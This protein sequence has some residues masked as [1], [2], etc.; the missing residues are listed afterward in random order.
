VRALAITMLLVSA[1]VS[2]QTSS[3]DIAELKSKAAAGDAQ[4]QVEL[5][6][7]YEAGKEV[8]QN[9][10]QAVQ[11]Y[12]AAADQGDAEG[13]N[14]L[15]LMYRYGHGVNKDIGEALKWFRKAAKQGYASAMFNLATV[16]YN[17]QEMP[18]NDRLAYVWFALAERAG[19]KPATDGVQRLTAEMPAW[20]L[21]E[22][23]FQ[24]AQMLLLGE[25]VPA[26]RP[27]ALEIYKDLGA[28][29][30]V[31]S[32]VTLGRLYIYGK[33][34]PQ[35][36]T[37]AAEYCSHAA[38]AKY[39]PGM[40]CL[41]FLNAAGALGPG[42]D[43]EAFSWYEKAAKKGSAVGAYGLASMYARGRGTQQDIQLAYMWL[44]IAADG[45]MQAAFDPLKA[46]AERLGPKVTNRMAA[47][48]AEEIKKM[49]GLR[50]HADDL[51]FPHAV[52]FEL[53][54]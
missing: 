28:D 17:D 7:A 44:A 9:D 2:A 48:A 38:K 22:G 39:V 37:K 53:P 26:D 34:V 12:R 5:G 41:A 3:H 18:P 31:A 32:W 40:T 16:Y 10:A 29:G 52:K 45:N 46:L 20:K 11:W 8:A 25:E 49:H 36:Y 35:D 14:A 47:K 15:A 51:Q 4:A 13:Q 23:R 1:L 54:R 43:A 24:V 50:L 6:R 33:L 21:R 42:H 30:A 19:S 27:R